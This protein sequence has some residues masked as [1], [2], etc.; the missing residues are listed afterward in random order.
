MAKKYVYYKILKSL[1][2]EKVTALLKFNKLRLSAKL[3]AI[4]GKLK[5]NGRKLISETDFSFERTW[6]N[7][8]NGLY[9]SFVIL[10]VTH[11]LEHE[12]R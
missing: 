3:D 11:L 12:I 9:L 8:W 6:E 5:I 10:H 7:F 4:N 2:F 1:E